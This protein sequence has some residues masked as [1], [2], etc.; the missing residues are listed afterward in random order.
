MGCSILVRPRLILGLTFSAVSLVACGQRGGNNQFGDL[1]PPVESNGAQSSFGP[2]FDQAA[3]AAPN[4]EPINVVDGDM[5][6]VDL[7]QEPI[8][9]P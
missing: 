6:P 9:V 4:S 8:E 7:T 5:P 1:S 3:K 2:R